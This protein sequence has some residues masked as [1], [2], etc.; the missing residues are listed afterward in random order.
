MAM[1][2]SMMERHGGKRWNTS[3]ESMLTALTCHNRPADM[4]DF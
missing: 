1:M 4:N 2:T 3:V